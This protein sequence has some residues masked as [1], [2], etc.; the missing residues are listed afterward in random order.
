[1][2]VSCETIFL[3]E[4]QKNKA[5]ILTK[6]NTRSARDKKRDAWVS[7]QE[8]LVST[9]GKEYSV[10]QLCKKWNNLQQ[11]VKEKI[12]N[13]GPD[14][15]AKTLH[16]RDLLCL[17]IIGPE[18]LNIG[19]QLDLTEME[20]SKM[21]LIKSEVQEEECPVVVK[22]G[23]FDNKLVDALI[24]TPS[25]PE[26]SSC[27]QVLDL[28]TSLASL[29]N[30]L[31]KGG[32]LLQSTPGPLQT[33]STLHTM[34]SSSDITIQDIDNIQ[35]SIFT[36]LANRISQID[37]TSSTLSAVADIRASNP[38]SHEEMT[39]IVTSQQHLPPLNNLSSLDLISDS[40]HA[41]GECGSPFNTCSRTHDDITNTCSSAQDGVI[42]L[43]RDMS[44]DERAADNR[45]PPIVVKEV[46]GVDYTRKRRRVASVTSRDLSFEE[47]H[48]RE[49]SILQTQILQLKKERLVLKNEK[50]RLQIEKLRKD[51]NSREFQNGSELVNSTY[52]TEDKL[53][54]R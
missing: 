37:G 17:H 38:A 7:I 20:L 1:M 54:D 33:K 40:Q 18:N 27:V 31:S 9:S 34:T 14:K 52:P 16:E 13:Y 11:R 19:G 8:V 26:P 29:Q 12:R 50:T 10:Q 4:L 53:D 36:E 42:N 25:S 44:D 41:T 46:P 43:S 22:R 2:D 48:S 49:C 28:V 23:T 47:K 24:K 5:T 6:E 3:K 51:F 15:A 32:D 45:T 21:E 39:D 30:T 35:T